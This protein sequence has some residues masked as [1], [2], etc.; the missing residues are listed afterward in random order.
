MRLPLRTRLP[1]A[2]RG[3]AWLAAAVLTARWAS[4]AVPTVAA[5]QSVDT[6][7]S[8]TASSPAAP[9]AAG[10][11]ASS[12]PAGQ[13][14]AGPKVPE[15]PAPAAAAGAL[16]PHGFGRIVSR[17]PTFGSDFALRV[18][19]DDFPTNWDSPDDQRCV[20]G[21]VTAACACRDAATHRRPCRRSNACIARRSA[22]RL[23]FTELRFRESKER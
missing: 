21:C 18:D 8:P 10:G 14:G 19:H 16:V 22:I 20:D 9:A 15:A 6:L 17:A 13:S 4:L 1:A 23:T 2:T 3:T 12:G 11:N 7:A 5:G